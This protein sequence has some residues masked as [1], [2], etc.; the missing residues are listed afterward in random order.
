MEF[1][2]P[3]PKL[4]SGA[5][6]ELTSLNFMEQ[7]GFKAVYRVGVAGKEEIFKLVCLPKEGSTDEEKAYRKESLGRIQREISLLGQ[8]K[9]FEI[10]KLG[11][12]PPRTVTIE[13]VEYIGYSEEFL[14]GPNLWDVLRARGPKPDEKEAKQLLLCLLIAIRE[15]W[16]FKA[17]HRDIKPQNMIKLNSQERPFVLL[18][19]GI[20]YS[21]ADPGLTRDPMIIPMTGRYF[22]PEMLKAD[23]RQNL[24]FRSDLYTAALTVFEYSA[25]I[26]PLAKTRD[27]LIR[28]ISRAVNQAPRLLKSDRPDFSDEFCD[29]ID[30][31]L[32]K[33]PALRPSNLSALIREIGGQI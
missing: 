29:L 27:D 12:I 13:G 20:A 23:F 31:L 9:S 30:K 2:P 4:I 18:D 16:T 11:S 7:G 10:V 3:D 14:D 21:L 32:K 19:L 24:D 26:H 33:I 5:F 8:C 17:I 15:L 25:Q 22:A 1:N 28:T 6:P